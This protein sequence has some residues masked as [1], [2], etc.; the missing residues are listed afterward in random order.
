MSDKKFD[1]ED[2]DPEKL[3]FGF[4]PSDKEGGGFSERFRSQKQEQAQEA[5][6]E[7]PA[8]GEM[9]TDAIL[10]GG[11]MM[12]TTLQQSYDQIKHFLI[13]DSAL[14]TA[15]EGVGSLL[16][17][18]YFDAVDEKLEAEQAAKADMMQEYQLETEAAKGILK[19]AVLARMLRRLALANI[20]RK[21]DL[22][23]KALGI[24]G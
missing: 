20:A 23:V 6:V 22:N 14:L 24:H 9:Q 10:M 4:G 12:D 17:D 19:Q 11:L 16:P 13:K 18:L 2:V 21:M 7:E 3:G 15:S 1:I 8:A 5:T